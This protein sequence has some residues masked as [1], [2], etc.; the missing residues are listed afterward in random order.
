MPAFSS[1]SVKLH[2][3]Y[4]PFLLFNQQHLRSVIIYYKKCSSF[5]KTS[6]VFGLVLLSATSES[7]LGVGI[8]Q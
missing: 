4:W 5:I 7:A 6:A 2:D 3:D 8:L 1:I